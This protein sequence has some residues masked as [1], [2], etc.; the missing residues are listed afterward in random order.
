M[1]L[2]TFT[3][4]AFGYSQHL[5]YLMG[6]FWSGLISL[7]PPGSGKPSR[8]LKSLPHFSYSPWRGMSKPYSPFPF[9]DSLPLHTHGRPIA[10]SSI[11]G[12]ELKIRIRLSFCWFT[13]ISSL[14]YIGHGLYQPQW[15]LLFSGCFWSHSP[16]FK[17]SLFDSY[18]ALTFWLSSPV[19]KPR[20]G[21]LLI[22]PFIS[23]PWLLGSSCHFIR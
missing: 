13:L 23:Y 15:F 20:R 16:I 14:I 10:L 2:V 7:V 5:E 11:I 6:F 8:P 3:L 12:E 17:L 1:H 18:L 19:P 4:L 9:T 21:K 22:F